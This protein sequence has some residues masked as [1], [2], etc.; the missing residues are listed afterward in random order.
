MITLNDEQVD[1]VMSRI[2]TAGLINRDLQND[3]VDHFCCFIESEINEGVDF[4]AAYKNALISIAPNGIR[5]IEDELFFTLLF[6]HIVMKRI[7]LVFGFLAAF[8]I[9]ASVLL[10]AEHLPG[11][12]TAVGTAFLLVFLTAILSLFYG[13]KQFKSHSRAYNT[14]MVVGFISASLISSGAIFKLQHLSTGNLQIASGVV[15]MNFIFLPMFFYHLY[16][17]AAVRPAASHVH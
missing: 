11:A 15:L 3:L 8:C 9:S 10:K 7:V 1:I 13:V 6:K 2:A 14:R 5:E 16:K 12:S 17:H 4:E